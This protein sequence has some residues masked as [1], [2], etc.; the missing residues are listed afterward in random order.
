MQ[1]IFNFKLSSRS[2]SFCRDKNQSSKGVKKWFV[3]LKSGEKY[4]NFSI[5]K[6]LEKS[7][8]VTEDEEE[9]AGDDDEQED[10]QRVI[11]QEEIEIL[12][13]STISF[14]KKSVYTTYI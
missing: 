13:K 6:I 11:K 9:E 1:K 4:S 2:K 5:N 10:Y 8:N 7:D 14:K 3:I 12:G